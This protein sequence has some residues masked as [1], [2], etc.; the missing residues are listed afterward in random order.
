M[1]PRPPPFR[2]ARK[3][4]ETDLEFQRLRS[5]LAD[6]DRTIVAIVSDLD[7]Q[8]KEIQNL[9][10]NRPSTGISSVVLTLREQYEDEH[11]KVLDLSKDLHSA[12]GELA[13]VRYELED[14]ESKHEEAKHL[15]KHRESDESRFEAAKQEILALEAKLE[16]K[17]SLLASLEMA[18]AEERQV[19]AA[20]C[21]DKLR[22]AKR[23]R[24]MEETIHEENDAPPNQMTVSKAPTQPSLPQYELFNLLLECQLFLLAVC[25]EKGP[26]GLGFSFQ[27][28]L[29][30]GSNKTRI[31][32]QEVKEGSP[33]CG[34][35]FEEDEVVDVNGFLCRDVP[36][37]LVAARLRSI[38]GPIRLVIAR[39]MSSLSIT[40]PTSAQV[41]SAGC[42]DTSV[43]TIDDVHAIC[44]ESRTQSELG[45]QEIRQHLASIESSLQHGNAQLDHLARQMTEEDKGDSS[46]HQAGP[47]LLNINPPLRQS[48]ADID[49]IRRRLETISEAVVELRA[50]TRR[51][52]AEATAQLSQVPPP[53]SDSDVL[54]P[55]I[56][57]MLDKKLKVGKEE[58]TSKLQVEVESLKSKLEQ[59]EIELSRRAE[60][61]AEKMAGESVKYKAELKTAEKESERLQEELESL[62]EA[63]RTN[64]AAKEEMRIRIDKLEGEVKAAVLKNAKT[65]EKAEQEANDARESKRTLRSVELELEREREDKAN[66]KEEAR[67]AKSALEEVQMELH[68]YQT[69]EKEKERI[70]GQETR[71]KDKVEAELKEKTHTV[72]ALQ[73]DVIQMQALNRAQ[74]EKIAGLE[75]TLATKIQALK[76]KAGAFL[77]TEKKLKEREEERTSQKEELHQ[78]QS[79]LKELEGSVAML[80]ERERR[81]QED[82]SNAIQKMKEKE[83]ETSVTIE[84]LT[85]K[86]MTLQEELSRKDASLLKSTESHA[87]SSG[88]LTQLGKEMERLQKELT[89]Q[90]ESFLQQ[91]TDM[92]RL[93]GAHDQTTNK[94]KKREERLRGLESEMSMIQKTNE[95]L[96][97]AHEDVELQ[98]TVAIK[99]RDQIRSK[100]REVEALLADKGQ[101]LKNI[102]KKQRE[103]Q[104]EKE[105]L[106][107]LQRKE[108]NKVLAGQVELA[109]VSKQLEA[110]TEERNRFKS[111]IKKIESDDFAL[112]EQNQQM[113]AT[114][115]KLS[116]ILKE[117]ET[118]R[119]K[120]SKQVI[121]TGRR[122]TEQSTAAEKFEKQA[123]SIEAELKEA[124]IELQKLRKNLA[125]KEASSSSE[126]SALKQANEILTLQLTDTTTHSGEKTRKLEVELKES[127]G[128]S[129]KLREEVYA[130]KEAALMNRSTTIEIQ[131][132]LEANKKEIEKLLASLEKREKALRTEKETTA[133]LQVKNQQLEVIVEG[134]QKETEKF[135]EQQTR[136]MTELSATQV[137]LQESQGAVTRA[138]TR[139]RDLQLHATEA[140]KD[141]AKF[142]ELQKDT[143]AKHSQLRL[144]IEQAE[145]KASRAE[146]ERQSEVEKVEQL[147]VTVRKLGEELEAASKA[148]DLAQSRVTRL[149]ERNRD[150]ERTI[151]QL[152]ESQR[153]LTENLTKGNEE[154]EKNIRGLESRIEVL[155]VQLKNKREEVDSIQQSQ[156]NLQAKVGRT[157]SENQ[158]LI[159]QLAKLSDLQARL[160]N[161]ETE[162]ETAKRQLVEEKTKNAVVSGERDQLMKILR[163]HGVQQNTE[164][165]STPAAMKKVRAGVATKEDLLVLLK[166]KDEEATRLKEYVDKMLI[167]VIDKAPF[168]LEAMK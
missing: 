48:A 82:A 63:K 111:K 59:R 116:G 14:L 157:D 56:E 41:T 162:T 91:Q 145:R 135:K 66:A 144:A 28:C 32:V 127:Q 134:L 120:L 147:Q 7:S 146:K 30:E 106:H 4:P 118:E 1:E 158:R 18:L 84:S 124:T 81:W 96:K 104:K 22:L 72:T 53:P 68:V 75:T 27:A 8:S 65:S 15:L 95:M 166:D 115:T 122:L 132:D 13:M 103:L 98:R 35:V 149:K 34:Q 130:L 26:N 9:Q 85:L 50:S 100:L 17:S 90:R 21:N 94:L 38:S 42:Q 97:D 57:E 129:H 19:A 114:C 61:V 156:A 152:L 77:E 131:T 46:A 133:V 160:L 55:A 105:D 155:K 36:Q 112:R 109:Q 16:D 159:D 140:D 137:R 78:N 141:T 117:T 49:D 58:A 5:S 33:V 161:A 12:K 153:S 37:S 126:I 110:V 29:L 138:E 64:E 43:H 62:R 154:K 71:E 80:R 74:E 128:E 163:D 52:E 60:E 86:N 45:T 79:R 20:L 113:E 168:V 125:Q 89:L 73:A 47:D 6:K 99:E 31:I 54:L 25:V 88:K 3:Q 165:P 92:I 102:A 139:C 39:K 142:R 150:A 2:G 107:E 10:A 167:A 119:V 93:Q 40:I 87:D 108:E 151:E 70:L 123:H 23:I 136:L 24:D 69:R 148:N 143:E 121:E 67:S 101:A 83:A 164:K 44:I 76:E 51:Q 11:A